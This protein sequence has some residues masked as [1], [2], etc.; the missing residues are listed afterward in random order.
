MKFSCLS[1][2]IA[3]APDAMEITPQQRMY[4]ACAGVVITSL[5][6]TPMDVV[7]TRFQSAQAEAV[8]RQTAGNS[9]PAQACEKC[10]DL[11]R[12]GRTYCTS[13]RASASATR[14]AMS[15]P[16]MAPGTM[17]EPPPTSQ[18]LP[19]GTLQALK[20]IA[21]REGVRGLY[22]GL[23]V[24]LVMAVPSTIF[25]YTAY[26][27]MLGKLKESGLSLSVAPAVAGSSARTMATLLLAPLEL[28]RTRAQSVGA[29]ALD[30]GN[31]GTITGAGTKVASA[32]KP[33][34]VFGGLVSVVREEGVMA[35]W[36]GVGTTMWRDVPFSVIYWVGYE[37]SK[38]LLTCSGSGAAT[39]SQPDA[40]GGS[41]AFL[42]KTFMAGASS[43]ALASLCT[44]PF[45][46]VKTQQQVIRRG[47]DPGNCEHLPPSRPRW[48][49]TF[50]VMRDIIETRGI[51]GLFSGTVA[52]I[53]KVAPSCAIMICSYES[54]KTFFLKQNAATLAK[55]DFANPTS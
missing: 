51:P 38:N 39:G 7:K 16:V 32:W 20:H 44:H 2:D 33:L 30:G 23:D 52:R 40:G 24:S 34:S 45:D 31:H 53:V 13:A 1:K 14:P 54:G 27:E 15:M 55:A 28:L 43:G 9:P 19:P 26:D 37:N 36:R 6:V 41:F 50:E 21:S 3:A 18:A 11:A 48:Q 5:V 4:S 17:L 8:S 10:L 12:K 35:L 47:A 42:S 25:Y 29:A 49:G 46:V 22:R